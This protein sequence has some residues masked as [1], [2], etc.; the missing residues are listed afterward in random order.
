MMSSA[1][2]AVFNGILV[3]ALL[4]ALTYVCTIPYRLDRPGRPTDGLAGRSESRHGDHP[5]TRLAA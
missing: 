5:V 3:A 1:T 4:A 2:V